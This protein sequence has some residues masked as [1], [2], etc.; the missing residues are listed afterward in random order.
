METYLAR[1]AGLCEKLDDDARRELVEYAE[2]LASRAGK[3]PVLASATTRPAEETV[4][5]AVRRLTRS[6][7]GLRKGSLM[8]PMGELVSQHILGAR[9]AEEVIEELES[10]YARAHANRVR[11]A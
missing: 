8:Q 4:L 7:P 3:A 11:R 2:L 6:Y 10:L 9:A 5:Q 1:L